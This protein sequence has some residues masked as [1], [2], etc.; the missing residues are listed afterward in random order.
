MTLPDVSSA[1]HEA[2][3]ITVPASRCTTALVEQLREVLERH[4]GPSNVRMTLTS[5]G[6]ECIPGAG[7]AAGMGEHCGVA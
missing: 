7:C 5:P 2:V 6:R 4:S 1:T 3:T